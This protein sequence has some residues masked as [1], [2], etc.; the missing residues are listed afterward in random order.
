MAGPDASAPSGSPR[1]GLA[2]AAAT[3]AALWAAATLAQIGARPTSV[4]IALAVAFVPYAALLA[5]P[6]E[7]GRRR[8]LCASAALAAA[9][10]LALVAAPSV[11]SDDLYRYLWDGRVLLHGLDPYRWAPDDPALAHLRDPLWERV[12]HREIP[13]IY[14]PLAQALFGL[15]GAIAHAAWPIKLLGLLAHLG[16][17]PLVARL[18]GERGPQA[19]WAWA[20]N[21]LALSE[22]AL[23]GH[24]DAVAALAVAGFVLALVGA[25]PVR[26][27]VLAGIASGLK[28]I[29]IA[30]APLVARRSRTAAV[31]AVG[32]AVLPAVPL[33][34]AGRG[35]EAA[36]G[37]SQYASRWRGNEGPY[38]LIEAGVRE[39]LDQAGPLT[40]APPGH[41]HLQ[42]LRGPL[43]AARGT[44]F[45]PRA[46]VTA[47][48]KAVP[49]PVDFEVG[50]LAG[51]LSR[52]L[53]LA[54]VLGA[55]LLLVRR[56]TP[57]LMAA[58][59]VLLI[60]LLLA[61]QVHPWYLLWLLPLEIATGRLAG[62]AWS[63]VVLLAYAPLDGWQAA[64]EWH[65]PALGRAVEYGLV[66][67]VLAC[68]ALVRRPRGP[69]AA[70]TSAR[71]TQETAL[72]VGRSGA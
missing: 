11:L 29:G 9:A 5:W 33:I 69:A 20:L 13:T 71:E 70:A 41:I 40:G 21:P 18:A 37:V 30:L 24:V 22:A 2:L 55:A 28:L 57:P 68:E 59:W 42:A 31:L 48:K 72:P 47:A 56:R 3:V 7:L 60:A 52:A 25:R 51:L 39:A 54:T 26:A 46:P 34:G 44:P 63:A 32:L 45:D 43:E 49:D 23:G 10:G 8:S 19:A 14:P 61:P 50:Y 16:T 15:A 12:S 65:Q 53:V 66:L 67:L 58:R 35:S 27:A 6:P 1:R 62:L 64:R 4:A 36:A 38:A 17:L